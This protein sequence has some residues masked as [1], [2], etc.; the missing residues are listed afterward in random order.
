MADS[1]PAGDGLANVNVFTAATTPTSTQLTDVKSV[2]FSPFVGMSGTCP[3]FGFF[4][5]LFS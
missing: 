1:R 4:H 5:F 3:L 2:W